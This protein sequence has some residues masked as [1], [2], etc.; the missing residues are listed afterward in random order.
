MTARG[1]TK[2]APTNFLKT[3]LLI[4]HILYYHHQIFP[5]KLPNAARGRAL[6]WPIQKEIIHALYTAIQIPL[7]QSKYKIHLK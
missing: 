3:M 5:S 2:F 7:F 6:R 4:S 1:R